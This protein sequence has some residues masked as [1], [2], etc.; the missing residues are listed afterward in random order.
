MNDKV[1]CELLLI[2]PYIDIDLEQIRMSNGQS[3]WN[4]KT[5]DYESDAVKILILTRLAGSDR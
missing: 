3:M 2:L 1:D 4:S 5:C